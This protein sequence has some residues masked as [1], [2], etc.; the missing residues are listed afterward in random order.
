M[1]PVVLRN[2]AHTSLPKKII[3]KH[4]IDEDEKVDE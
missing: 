4:G 2:R 3:K 1:S